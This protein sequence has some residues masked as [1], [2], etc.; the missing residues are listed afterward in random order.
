MCFS[1]VCIFMCLFLCLLI[2]VCI[3]AIQGRPYK[4]QAGVNPFRYGLSDQFLVR[5]GGLKGPP[6]YMAVLGPN[7]A[8]SCYY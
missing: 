4:K 7:K 3:S 2:N 5:G 6:R 1:G 8:H